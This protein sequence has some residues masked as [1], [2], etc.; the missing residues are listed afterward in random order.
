MHSHSFLVFSVLLILGG[1]FTLAGLQTTLQTAA[2]NLLNFLG[3]QTSVIATLNSIVPQSNGTVQ[4]RFDPY[5]SGT[6]FTLTLN[7]IPTTQLYPGVT[8]AAITGRIYTFQYLTGAGPGGTDLLSNFKLA[9]VT[10]TLTVAQSASGSNGWEIIPT[11]GG[12]PLYFETSPGM[13]VGD[14]YTITY[15]PASINGTAYA[16]LVGT[17]ILQT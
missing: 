6:G 5:P 12:S 10:L 14:T 15:I 1:A 4:L 2:T 16:W 9:T 3:T 13:T 17:P 11:G 8:S 7:S